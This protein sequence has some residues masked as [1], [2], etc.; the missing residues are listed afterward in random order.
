M[1]KTPQDGVNIVVT[2]HSDGSRTTVKRL[3]K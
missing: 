2:T 1:S 3:N